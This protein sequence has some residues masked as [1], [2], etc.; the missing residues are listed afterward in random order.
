LSSGS[1]QAVSILILSVDTR[2]S[3]GRA[4]FLSAVEGGIEQRERRPR[5]AGADRR[6]ATDPSGRRSALGRIAGGESPPR[7]HRWVE[8]I[9]RKR[10]TVGTWVMTLT[11]ERQLTGQTGDMKIRVFAF[12]RAAAERKLEKIARSCYG[13]NFTVVAIARK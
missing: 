9:T 13:D 11:T 6:A 2:A 12:S 1:R 7:G 10:G 8:G 4:A 5:A 3:R